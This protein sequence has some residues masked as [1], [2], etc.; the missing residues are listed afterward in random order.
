M[1]QLRLADIKDAIIDGDSN[2]ATR[3]IFD[4]NRTFGSENPIGYE[5][6]DNNAITERIINK[7]KKRAN[8]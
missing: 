1:K 6:W 2:K 5:D 4:Y 8:P 7:A 3:L